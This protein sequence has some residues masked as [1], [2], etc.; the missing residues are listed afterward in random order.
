MIL[1]WWQNLPLFLVLCPLMCG[2]ACSAL[3]GKASRCVTAAMCAAESAGMAVLLWYTASGNV[4]FTYAM[5]EIG[6]TNCGRDPRRR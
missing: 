3:R 1:A 6:A 4:S 5:G 2:V